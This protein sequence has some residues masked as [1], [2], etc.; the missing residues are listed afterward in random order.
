MMNIKVKN[1][2]IRYIKS[3]N[4]KLIL[5]RCMNKFSISQQNDKYE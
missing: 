3:I 4:Y 1:K 5:T 2:Y